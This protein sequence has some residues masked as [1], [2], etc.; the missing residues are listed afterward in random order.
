[1]SAIWGHFDLNPILFPVV[2]FNDFA[3]LSSVS[4][5]KFNQFDLVHL[6]NRLQMDF[7]FLMDPSHTRNKL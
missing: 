4:D 6:K 1:M 3:E 5:T 2:S 7:F